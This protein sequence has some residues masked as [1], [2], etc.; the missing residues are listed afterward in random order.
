MILVNISSNA[1]ESN[2]FEYDDSDTVQKIKTDLMNDLELT[3]DEDEVI[4]NSELLF[5]F[6]LQL[7]SE[8]QILDDKLETSL[9]DLG[10]NEINIFVDIDYKESELY[11]D[12]EED[13]SSDTQTT[14]QTI[15]VAAAT[16]AVAAAAPVAAPI[17]LASA[18]A[19]SIISNIS[20]Y[21][22]WLVGSAING[23]VGSAINGV[24][25]IGGNGDVGNRVG[26]RGVA[27][28]FA[29]S[30]AKS[31]APAAAAPVAASLACSASVAAPKSLYAGFG[32]R[33]RVRPNGFHATFKNDLKTRHCN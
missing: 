3:N 29:R 10:S 24:G 7:E 16:A 5:S 30:A 14:A 12:Y 20:S 6:F 13:D 25:V 11:N 33:R 22:S 8:K 15:A 19:P 31:A 21:G 26:N 18:V 23:V 17:A 4:N 2:Q 1:F 32:S 28:S 9:S 27:K